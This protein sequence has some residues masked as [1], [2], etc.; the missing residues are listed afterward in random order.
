M[1][2]DRKTRRLLAA[3]VVGSLGF[4]VGSADAM[5]QSGRLTD[6]ELRPLYAMDSDI[7][8]G[9]DL[10]ASVCAK[11][12]GADGLS[13]AKGVPN[14]AGQRPSYLYRELRAYQAGARPNADMTE[15]VKFLSDDAIVK[16]AAYYASLD[17]AQPPAGPAPEYVSPAVGWK[18]AATPC[19]KCH[20]DNGISRK[21][22]VPSLVGQLPKYLVETMQSYV[23]DDRKLEATNEEMKTALAKLSDAELNQIALYY[24]TRAETLAHAQTPIDGNPAVTKESVA[25]CIRCHG[26]DGVGTSPVSPSIAGQDWTYMVRSLRAYK[27]GSRDDPVMGP[28]ARKLEDADMISLS[29]HYASLAPKPTGLARP[30]SPTEWA[31]KCD[32][33]HGLNGNSARLDVP[34]LAAQKQDYLEQ[35]LRAYKAG[36][37]K[38]PEMLAMSDVLTEDDIKA[39]AAYYAY[40]KARAVVFVMAPGK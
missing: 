31:D 35:A 16:V 29:A 2:I 14:I 17:P 18:A 12:H 25:R 37:R 13:T 10:A 20:G 36:T 1:A 23:S 8:E 30:L 39:L 34:A 7:R 24:A 11:C 27:D 21:A 22:G 40:Q 19:F 28:P 3:M 6:D 15:K 32:R 33:C 9:K 5:A 4:L 38:N 26:E